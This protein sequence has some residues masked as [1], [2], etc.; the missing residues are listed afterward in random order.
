MSHHEPTVD[1]D[2]H[3]AEHAANAAAVFQRLRDTSPVGWT[4]AH[5]GFWIVSRYEDVATI[6]RDD[7]TF[8][9]AHDL[10]GAGN[11]FEGVAIPAPPVHMI[12]LEVDPPEFYGYRRIVNPAFSPAAVERWRG[13]VT[14]V[15]T[16]CLDRSVET[17]SIDFVLDLANP[18]PAILT[19]K[20]LGL[21]LEDWNRYAEPMHTAVYAPP[22]S[23][24]HTRASADQLWIV[25]RLMEAIE[26]R[27]TSPGD[28]LL[29]DLAG[30]T[31]ENGEPVAFADAVATAYTVMAGGVD[32]TTAL[33]GN[34]LFW[35]GA[36]PA[37]RQR[38]IND[39]MLIPS[40]R[41]EFLRY[42]APAQAFARTATRDVEVR[43]CP[44][45]TRGARAPL[46]GLR[47]PRSHHLRRAGDRPPR[48]APEPAHILRTRDPPLSGLKPRPTRDRHRPGRGAPPDARLLGRCRQRRAV[49]VDRLDQWSGATSGDVHPRGAR[50]Q[51]PVASYRAMTGGSVGW[52]V[53]RPGVALVELRRPEKLGAID[54]SMLEQLN[55]AWAAIAR[56]PEVRAVVLTGKGRGFC[57]G[58]DVDAAFAG[59]DPATT[60]AAVDIPSFGLS[61]LEHDLWIPYIVAVNGVCAGGGFHLV[62]DADIVIAGSDARFLDPHV[63]I[64]QV[65]ALEPITLTRRIPLEAVLRMVV[66]GRDGGLDAS[67]ALRVGLV[68]EVVRPEKLVDRALDLATIAARSS[69]AAIEA[70]KR[71]VWASLNTGLDA[72]RKIGWDL[73]R[74]HW[75]HPDYQEGIAA[76]AERRE[77][78]WAP[79]GSGASRPHPTTEQSIT[80]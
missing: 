11:G 4:D 47:Q 80:G 3:S 34:A 33:I 22:G 64:G 50:R 57:T 62:T 55:H 15:V 40:A 26:E 73:L 71:A 48:S 58:L 16:A 52:S 74:R 20:V 21:P 9:S 18:L 32:T 37:E 29:S 75:E 51:S 61:P 42:F 2:Q 44:I 65:A 66:L 41:E 53:V 78:R 36:N 72:G 70:S 56:Q 28:D 69:P 23:D 77:P 59:D 68:S 30:A 31:F 6:A 49:R 27:R 7:A 35:L 19:L 45:A 13:F 67:D 79:R 43:G 1:F 76:F 14:D 25:G 60:D 12:P 24:E 63:S 46:V 17:G 10:S 8:S 38:L 5:G 54:R 39:P